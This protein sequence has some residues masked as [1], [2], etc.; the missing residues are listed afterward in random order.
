MKNNTNSKATAIHDTFCLKFIYIH[1]YIFYP[2]IPE[3]NIAS[4]RKSI[5]LTKYNDIT[6][7]FSLFNKHFSLNPLA[8]D[9]SKTLAYIILSS[10][11]KYRKSNGNPRLSIRE[12]AESRIKFLLNLL[13]LLN[14]EGRFMF[15][16]MNTLQFM[17]NVA[18]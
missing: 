7:A 11:L 9:I 1:T 18:T 14:I 16:T 10:H 5:W 8:S 12:K 15:Q 2:S 13:L 4:W 17:Y 6:G 3:I